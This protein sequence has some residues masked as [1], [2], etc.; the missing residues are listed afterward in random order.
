M[1]IT[2]TKDNLLFGVS[3]VQKAVSTK[4]TLPVLTCIRIEAKNNLLYFTGTDL[5]IGIQCH[6]PVEVI[7]EGV[8]IVPARHFSEIVRRLPDSTISIQQVNDGAL[9]IKYEDSQLS[10]KTLSASDFPNI[11]EV[12]GDNEIQ[13]KADIFKQMI[14]Q[15]IFAAGSDEGRPLF[16]GVLFEYEKDKIRL[17]ATDTHRL[18]L[19]QAMIETG[20]NE[21]L[22]C[23]IPAKIL[24]ELAR[25]IHD[26]EEI[27]HIKITKNLVSFKIA[28]ILIISRLLEGQFPN[29]RQVIP[30]K[31]NL[32]V[33]SSNKKFQEAVERIA[34]FTTLND[35]SNTVQIK[36]DNNIMAISS[37]SEIGQGYEQF[38]I[39][40][41]GENV[42]IS[43]N[44]KYLLD[45]F[46][47]M[48]AEIISVEFT[49]P[50]SP[51]IIRPAESENF[52]CLLLPV[53]T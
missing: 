30:N 29:Y 47:V 42:S 49:G 43:F 22:N 17:I 18:A 36:I 8:A 44:A 11:P 52:I 32:K 35:N 4:S 15:T 13:I 1:K 2:A 12:F 6:I 7:N 19:R 39:E 14:R 9:L 28:N 37:K 38:G 51:C 46:K 53:R 40:S 10:I 33:K 50:L 34:L 25:L 3:A 27:C 16:T 26:D 20:I 5:E 48:D 23:I 41:E 21:N 31:Y 24:G 45:A